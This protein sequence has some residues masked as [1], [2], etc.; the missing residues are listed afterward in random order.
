MDPPAFED[1]HPVLDP[2]QRL[3]RRELREQEPGPAAIPRMRGEQ[4]GEG[5]ASWG[6]HSSPRFRG[7][8]NAKLVEG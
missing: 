6:R 8:G 5:R 2:Q 1:R 7:E 4:F 3:V